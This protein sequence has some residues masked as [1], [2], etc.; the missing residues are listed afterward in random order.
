MAP[1]EPAFVIFDLGNVLVHIA[2]EAFL[3]TLG[4]DTP[5]NRTYYQKKITDIVKMYERGDDTTDQFLARLGGLFNSS[6]DMSQ[7]HRGNR[8]YSADDFRRAM[9]S[10]IGRPV[11]GMEE[12]VRNLS[13]RVPLGLLSNTNPLHFDSC[14]EHL[15][16]LQFIPSHFLSYRLR[17]LKPDAGIFEQAVELLRLHA[18]E[19]FFVDDVPENV[20]AAKRV[21]LNSHLF[22]G[23]E[24]LKKR[25]ATLKLL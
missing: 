2:P 9:L 10:I 17:S 4:I 23:H 3:R 7:E 5:A 15:S 19:I 21:G 24:E 13:A 22:V 25:L 14:M 18:A 16:S 12:I 20:E 6:G 8:V 1:L 11:V